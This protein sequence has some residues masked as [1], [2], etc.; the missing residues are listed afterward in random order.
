MTPGHV[1]WIT[2]DSRVSSAH[3]TAVLT[4]PGEASATSRTKQTALRA[5]IVAAHEAEYGALTE[6]EIDSAH[7]ELFGEQH[8]QDTSGCPS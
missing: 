5:E 4:T 8:E 7:H 3:S 2:R 6:R 1:T